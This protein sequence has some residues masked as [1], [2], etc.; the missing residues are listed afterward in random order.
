MFERVGERLGRERVAPVLD[1]FRIDVLRFDNF[2]DQS[3]QGRHFAQQF[4][5]TVAALDAFGSVQQGVERDCFDAVDFVLAQRVVQRQHIVVTE[6]DRAR[7]DSVPR[8]FDLTTTLYIYRQYLNA[9]L[10]RKIKFRVTDCAEYEKMS[11]NA[12]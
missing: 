4:P 9:R 5:I 1:R 8:D 3:H 7:R 6:A 2:V 12:G 10:K 11:K